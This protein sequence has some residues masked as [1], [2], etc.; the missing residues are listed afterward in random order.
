MRPKDVVNKWVDAFNKADVE[1]FFGS[2]Y[3]Y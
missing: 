1:S 3:F 2:K